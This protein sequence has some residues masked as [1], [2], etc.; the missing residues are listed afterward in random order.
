[1]IRL[2]SAVISI[3][4]FTMIACN[5]PASNDDTPVLEFQYSSILG[6][7]DIQKDMSGSGSGDKNI[8]TVTV[9]KADGLW[10]GWEE[11]GY[12]HTVTAAGSFSFSAIF[13]GLT[14]ED[15]M[16]QGGLMVRE[17]LKGISAYAALRMIDGKYDPVARVT[18]SSSAVS[19]GSNAPYK[20]G[21][22]LFI[23]C[24]EQGSTGTTRNLNVEVGAK[25]DGQVIIS[26]TYTVSTSSDTLYIGIFGAD[27]SSSTGS[28]SVGEISI[29]SIK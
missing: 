7:S 19:S 13:K 23:Y 26:K 28:F 3:G 9:S 22:L 15:A 8:F 27:H 6:S 11:I 29:T 10:S 17:S 14:G 20:E 2:V 12:Y 21:D 18:G 4:V 24:A 16:S 1:M 5:N 25:R